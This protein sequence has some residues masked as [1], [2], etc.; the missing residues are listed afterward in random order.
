MNNDWKDAL[1]QLRDSLEE[2]NEEISEVVIE[3]TTPKYSQPLPL[4]VVIDRKGRNGKVATIIEGFTI[5]D[6][7][8]EELAR[9]MKQ[10]LGT[11]GSVRNKEILIQGDRKDEIIKFLQDKN[12]K[13]K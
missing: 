11:G 1:S 7:E 3:K 10:K 2:P 5:M 9:L 4:H 13:V 12:F 6:E 8:V